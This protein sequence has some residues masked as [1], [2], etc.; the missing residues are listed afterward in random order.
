MSLKIAIAGNIASGKTAVETFFNKN[1]Y[2]VLDTDKIGHEIL[3]SDTRFEIL[4][5]FEN[6]DI[7]NNGIMVN[8]M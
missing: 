8:L 1:G 3:N 2:E 6:E 4:K 7:S 5:A